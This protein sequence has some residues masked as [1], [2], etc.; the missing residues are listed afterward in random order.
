MFATASSL[1]SVGA[2]HKSL[3]KRSSKCYIECRPQLVSGAVNAMRGCDACDKPSR[4]KTLPNCSRR[5][6]YVRFLPLPCW[7]RNALCNTSF[8]ARRGRRALQRRP[9]EKNE[10]P[11][12]PDGRPHRGP[13]KGN[14]TF[15][16]VEQCCCV[17]V[18]SDAPH[19]CIFAGE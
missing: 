4:R 8:A 10:R 13:P 15:I 18:L 14:V 3:R 7:P 19:R 9:I 5:I 2:T 12:P 11:K 6:V 1:W 16:R 17:R